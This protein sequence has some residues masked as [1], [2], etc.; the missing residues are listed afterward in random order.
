MHYDL[1]L[2]LHVKEDSKDV[3]AACTKGCEILLRNFPTILMR[4]A[5]SKNR[6]SSC[7]IVTHVLRKYYHLVTCIETSFQMLKMSYFYSI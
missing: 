1:T 2:K 6:G 5:F 4:I 7:H 3:K